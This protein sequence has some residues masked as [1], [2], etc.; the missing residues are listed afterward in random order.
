MCQVHSTRRRRAHAGMRAIILP[1]EM[2]SG[3]A[4]ESQRDR[5]PSNGYGVDVGSETRHPTETFHLCKHLKKVPSPNTMSHRHANDAAEASR[6][7]CD[8]AEQPH[9]QRPPQYPTKLPARPRRRHR[10]TRRPPRRSDTSAARAPFVWKVSPR[11]TPASCTAADIVTTCSAP[12]RGWCAARDAPSAT[13]RSAQT[14]PCWMTTAARVAA[15]LQ[16]IGGSAGD[17]AAALAS[18]LMYLR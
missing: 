8:A 18:S 9:L 16:Q 10:R 5:S 13:A 6:G 15:T 17:R 11:T 7:V 3:F 1:F 2:P 4:C 12:S 14:R